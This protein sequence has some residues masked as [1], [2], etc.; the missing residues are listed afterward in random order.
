MSTRTKVKI[1]Y[2]EQHR[3]RNY[4]SWVHSYIWVQ[5]S[6]I[7]ARYGENKLYQTNVKIVLT[8]DITLH[9]YDLLRRESKSVLAEGL[10]VSCHIRLPNSNMLLLH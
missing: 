8:R 6:G 1:K 2:L 7:Q 9:L 5:H 4:K 10:A 3:A